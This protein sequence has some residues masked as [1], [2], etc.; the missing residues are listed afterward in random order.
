MAEHNPCE[1][2][3]RKMIRVYDEIIETT[4][5]ICVLMEEIEELEEQKS[6][7]EKQFEQLGRLLISFD[8]EEGKM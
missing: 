8:E 5:Q 4:E 7:K 6:I 2:V 3:A 1:S